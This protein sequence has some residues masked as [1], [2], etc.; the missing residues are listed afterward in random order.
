MR[1]LFC[2]TLLL[3]RGSLSHKYLIQIYISVRFKEDK[4]CKERLSPRLP[5]YL[6]IFPNPPLLISVGGNDIVISTN[7]KPS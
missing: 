3:I 7:I 6:Q 5:G 1:L 2:Y 4:V